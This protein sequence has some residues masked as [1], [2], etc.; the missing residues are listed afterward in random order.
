MEAA[1]E[2]SQ[3]EE[4]ESR[5]GALK[6]KK[7]LEKLHKARLEDAE[8]RKEAKENH[9]VDKESVDYF[10]S[11][12]NVE[13]GAVEELLCGCLG[14]DEKAVAQ[15]LEEATSKT[16]QLQ[17][18][19][20]DSMVFL[21]TYD[22]RKAQVA[23][24]KLQTSLNETREQALP[25]K[26]FGFRGRTKA[27]P[28]SATV[29]DPV[30]SPPADHGASHVDGDPPSIQ[31]TFSNMSNM[32]LTKTS[33]EIT[34]EDVLL[35]HLSNCKVRLYGTPGT[36]HL[37][38]IDRCE[39]LCGPVSTSVFVDRCE[40]STLALACQQLRTHNTKNTRVY[41]HVT[42]RAIVEDCHGVSFAPYSWSY[43]NLEEDFRTA[44]LDPKRNNWDQVADF[45]WLAAGTPSPNWTVIPEGDRKTTWDL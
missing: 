33:E 25:K 40:S 7:R 5:N 12:F 21:T 45:N 29:E 31:C 24:Q 44:G 43:P 16:V 3:V 17:K 2:V 32:V 42:S 22:Q 20:N 38:H 19:L 8:R 4:S 10:F 13:R 37:K 34:K 23:L 14:A 41:L 35:S 26:K 39:I 11:T 27:T 15:R 36:L 6:M 30:V 28:A 1:D 9:T 18:F